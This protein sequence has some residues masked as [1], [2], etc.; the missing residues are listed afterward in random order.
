MV[1]KAHPTWWAMP[2]LHCTGKTPVLPK[3]GNSRGRLFYIKHKANT[4]FAPTPPSPRPSPPKSGGR[5]GLRNTGWKPVPPE[6]PGGHGPPYILCHQRQKRATRRVAP[7]I[8]RGLGREFEGR[9]G[10]F[11]ISD[12]PALP[13][14]FSG[15]GPGGGRPWG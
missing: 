6:I 1:R 8:Y 9:A 2:A 13:S 15:P 3:V 12:P 14:R 4:R 10:E 5:G 11:F 7:T